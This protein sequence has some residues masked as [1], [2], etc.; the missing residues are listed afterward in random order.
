MNLKADFYRLIVLAVALTYG[1]CPAMAEESKKFKVLVVMSYEDDYPW[2]KEIR[3]GT[4]SVLKQSCEVRYFY[5]DTKKN[6]AGGEQKAKEAYALYK[7][8]QPDGVIVADDDAQ[9]MFVVP[10]LKDKVKT[11][12][13]FCGVNADPEKYGYPASNISGILERYHI[14]QSIAFAK[15]LNPSIGTI[16]YITKDGSTGKA[17]SDQVQKESGA[18]QIKSVD[19]KL[20]N[21]M[22]DAVTVTESFKEQCDLLFITSLEGIS[23]EAG[24]PMTQK[25]IIPILVKNFGKLTISTSPH[26][27]KF[28]VLCAVVQQGQEH[29]STAAEMLL[30]AMNGTPVSQIP[31]TK[32]HQGKRI[33]NATVLK[34][35]GIKPRPDI[36]GSAE[37]VKTEN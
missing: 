20:V 34:D 35:L 25:D 5:M 28:G 16:G 19:F 29:G 17:I 4:D 3:E 21:T 31:I 33:I 13:M 15:Q 23:D 32:N 18:Y 30:K 26:L 9:T 27:L 22:K 14:D 1:L 8:F 7:E 2:V 36:L 6:L 37:L 12:V 24:K 11:P 10:Y